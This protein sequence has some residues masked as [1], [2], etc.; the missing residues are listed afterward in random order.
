MEIA[1][2]RYVP[3]K[4]CCLVQRDHITLGRLNTINLSGAKFS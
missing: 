2:D 3:L 1:L 4:K